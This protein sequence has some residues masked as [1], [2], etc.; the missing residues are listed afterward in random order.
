M[1]FSLGRGKKYGLVVLSETGPIFCGRG[2]S[3]PR[4][5]RHQ[6]DTVDTSEVHRNPYFLPLFCISSTLKYIDKRVP[7]VSDKR[8]SL[9]FW[10][11]LPLSKNKPWKRN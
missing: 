11:R 3:S 4:S 10:G 1:L 9:F 8:V 7:Q 2:L 6:E 5:K